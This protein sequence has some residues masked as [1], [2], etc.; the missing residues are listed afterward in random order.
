MSIPFTYFFFLTCSNC[1]SLN[2]RIIDLNNGSKCNQEIEKDNRILF[3]SN[4]VCL[5]IYFTL[6]NNLYI[7][8]IVYK[9]KYFFLKPAKRDKK[10]NIGIPKF[11]V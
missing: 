4:F 5:F 8:A 6:Y 1:N 3:S 2:F 11:S 7:L 9:A 10:I